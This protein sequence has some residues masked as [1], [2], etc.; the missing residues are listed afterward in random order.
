MPGFS[1]TMH[2]K[3]Q[4]EE[5]IYFA[6]RDRELILRLHEQERAEHPNTGADPQERPAASRTGN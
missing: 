3:E 6:R 4:A 2:L 5:D 1:E